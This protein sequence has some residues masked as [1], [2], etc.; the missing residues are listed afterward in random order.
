MLVTGSFAPG[1]ILMDAQM[2]GLSGLPLIAALRAQTDACI[3]LISA[4]APPENLRDAADGFLLKPFAPDDLDKFINLRSFLT[5]ESPTKSLRSSVSHKDRGSHPFRKDREKD[6]APDNQA[7][8]ATAIPQETEGVLDA[9][10]LAALRK[11]MPEAAIREI[12]TV[13][14]ADMKQRLSSIEAA[15]VAGDAEQVRRIGHSIKG[16]CAMTGATKAARLAALIETGA[17][18]GVAFESRV[19]TSKVNQLDNKVPIL[20]DLHIAIGH[21]EA[22]LR[23]GF[24]I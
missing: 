18:D 24:S 14:V 20:N 7:V 19:A 2:P 8:C 9:E 12:F 10:T 21:L 22:M 4:S 1:L 5:P 15:L 17:L 23:S 6:G 13:L 16:A 3:C 11:V